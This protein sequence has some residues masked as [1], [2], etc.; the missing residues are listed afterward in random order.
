MEI[1]PI[2][3]REELV[4]ASKLLIAAVLGAV[5]SSV[6]TGSATVATPVIRTYAS[7]VRGRGALHG[8]RWAIWRMWRPPPALW[9]TW[10]WASV[11]SERWYRVQGCRTAATPKGLTTAATIWCTAA[12][13]VAVGLNMF[14]IAADRRTAGVLPHQPAPP[15]LVRALETAHQGQHQQQRLNISHQQPKTQHPL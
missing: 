11:S 3:I 2:D 1:H 9:P 13:G 15:R 4:I 8:H 12:I 14:V 6:T 7:G 5:H 10:S